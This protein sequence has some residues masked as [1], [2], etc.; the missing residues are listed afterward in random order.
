MAVQPFK[1]LY[2][3]TGNIARSPLAEVQTRLYVRQNAD[4]TGWIIGS[5]GIQA[6]AGD[7][8]RE[9]AQ[10]AAQEAGL[11]LSEH[12]A[13]VLT[14]AEV[15]DNDLVLTMSWDQAA[16]VWSVAPESWGKSFTIKEFIHWSRQT[17]ARPA[18][19]FPDK[20]SRLRDRVEQAHAVRRRARADFGFWGGLRPQDLSVMEPEGRNE[21]TWRAFF[22]SVQALTTDV[23]HL[24]GGP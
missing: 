15:A 23:V 16:H 22:Q 8:A 13:K 19:L 20:V 12:R 18:I 11:D 21:A 9:A 2:V 1:L 17:T 4:A 3:C 10:R 24:L 5:V 14:P 7:P 6:I